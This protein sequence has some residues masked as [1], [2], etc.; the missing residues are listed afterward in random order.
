MYFLYMYLYMKI[1][2][3]QYVSCF[4]YYILSYP[5][6]IELARCLSTYFEYVSIK[7]I[8]DLSSDVQYT[9]IEGLFMV[10]VTNCKDIHYIY[11]H[12]CAHMNYIQNIQYICTF[13]SVWIDSLLYFQKLKGFLRFFKFFFLSRGEVGL[14]SIYIFLGLFIFQPISYLSMYVQVFMYRNSFTN[15]FKTIHTHLLVSW[16]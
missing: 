16:F 1:Y 8:F 6:C 12:V 13:L 14:S 3:F 7:N 11:T 9:Y 10:F 2:I 4:V 5:P 15:V